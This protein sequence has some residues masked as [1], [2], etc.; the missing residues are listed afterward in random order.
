M[1]GPGKTIVDEK[2]LLE[3]FEQGY[4]KLVQFL[5]NHALFDAWCAEHHKETR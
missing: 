4:A 5:T 1:P 2:W 3:W